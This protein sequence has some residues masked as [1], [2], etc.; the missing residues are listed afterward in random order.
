MERRRIHS[1]QVE[2]SGYQRDDGLW[3]IEGHLT[4]TKTYRQDD[5]RSVRREVGEPIHDLTMRL[6][7]DEAFL[8]HG[9][10]VSIGNTP[11]PQCS[12]VRDVYGRLVGLTI[13]AGFLSKVRG[14]VGGVE[15]CTHLT[16]LLTPMATVAF[17]TIWPWKYLRRTEAGGT[18]PL[19][20]FAKDAVINRCRTLRSDGDVVRET[21]PE[22][23]TGS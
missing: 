2:C 4:D 18:E 3:D 16:D 23:Y 14:L 22:H 8:I 13:G 5:G 6:T 9:V 7:I 12:L 20:G 11:H 10:A 15:G 1:R 19:Q 21:W 17:Q